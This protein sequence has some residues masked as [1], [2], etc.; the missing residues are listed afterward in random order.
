[1]ATHGVAG[2]EALGLPITEPRNCRQ[3]ISSA[4]MRPA[5]VT[6]AMQL[7]GD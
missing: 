6:V 4:A 2:L 1:M 5:G 7:A 3:E